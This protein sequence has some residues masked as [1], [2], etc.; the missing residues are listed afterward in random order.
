MLRRV[1]SKRIG[2]AFVMKIVIRGH[3]IEVTPDHPLYVIA[4][5][6]DD[7]VRQPGWTC[8]GHL[9]PGDMLAT[10]NGE[11]AMVQAVD[12]RVR[13]AEVC[14]LE[15]EDSHTYFVGGA[16]WGFSV[17]A[18][19]GA[20]TVDSEGRLTNGKYTVN[21]EAMAPHQTG[22]PGAGKS[23]WLFNVDAETATLEAATI[24]DAS[25]LWVGNK[26]KVLANQPVG[27]H[28]ET[29]ELTS[30][31]NVYRRNS[32]FIHGAPGSPL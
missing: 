3:I 12:N 4:R 1:L 26:A 11:R 29:G 5:V 8:A 31:I 13:W 20:C 22:S 23:Q 6:D 24:A 9:R 16:D 25:G 17:W 30:T 7:D 19:N 28:A 14:N 2:Y 10:D 15:V 27:V 32:G 18:H 21:P